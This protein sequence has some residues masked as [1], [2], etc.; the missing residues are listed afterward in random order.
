MQKLV[1]YYTLGVLA[2]APQGLAQ[3][4]AGAQPIHAVS[5]QYLADL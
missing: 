4:M 5:N 2:K 3:I 1:W